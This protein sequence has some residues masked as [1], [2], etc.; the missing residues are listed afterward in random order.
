MPSIERRPSDDA[1]DANDAIHLQVARIVGDDVPERVRQAVYAVVAAYRQRAMTFAELL[2]V[3]ID[4][5]RGHY[6]RTTQ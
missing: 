3:A 4:V 6:V 2:E 1:S 5:T